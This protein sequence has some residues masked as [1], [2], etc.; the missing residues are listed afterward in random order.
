MRIITKQLG[1]FL[2]SKR[3]GLWWDKTA[4]RLG[5]QPRSDMRTEEG[6]AGGLQQQTLTGFA[7]ISSK[8]ITQQ[9]KEKRQLRL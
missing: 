1:F 3:V 6:A 7:N 2:N 8:K 4:R 5:I 9:F